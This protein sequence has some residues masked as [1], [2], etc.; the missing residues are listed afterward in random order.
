MI[1]H[2]TLLNMFP[3]E[4]FDPQQ[5]KPFTANDFIQRILIPE[6]AL[7]LIME[8]R[9]LKGFIGAETALQVLR[10]STAY[11]AA[12][13][14]EDDSEGTIVK[15]TNSNEDNDY[16]G[17]FDIG[18]GDKIVMERARK[19][20]KEIEEELE[21]QRELAMD[22]EEEQKRK[23]RGEVSIPIKTAS[24]VDERTLRTSPRPKV[25][26]RQ[27]KKNAVGTDS[28]VVS[29][30]EG[31]GS[32]LGIKTDGSQP[33]SRPKRNTRRVNYTDC[34]SDGDDD[35]SLEKRGR[36]KTAETRPILSAR[37]RSSFSR[38]VSAS[39]HSKKAAEAQVHFFSE[40]ASLPT[41]GLGSDEED[42]SDP[43]LKLQTSS[44]SSPKRK[45]GSKVN[46]GKHDKQGRTAYVD[47]DMDVDTP[48]PKRRVMKSIA[49]NEDIDLTPRRGMKPDQVSL[50]QKSGLRAHD[51]VLARA[52]A[53]T[54]GAR[55]VS[56]S[57]DLLLLCQ[58]RLM[59]VCPV[60]MVTRR[61]KTRLQPWKRKKVRRSL[62]GFLICVTILFRMIVAMEF[63]LCIPALLSPRATRCFE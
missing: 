15:K 35:E 56:S 38:Q 23:R 2:Q 32:D 51:S 1:I 60:S 55:C 24:D 45:P 54:R 11:G 20:R 34:S 22:T 44:A 9:G 48:M 14:P 3:L 33:R 36:A 43:K 12:M 25:S 41:I 19:R 8:D 28:D 18:I 58:S 29:I 57:Q 46:M 13:F 53:R 4:S 61:G 7:Q 27:R 42:W 26:S 47:V 16:N 49:E 59:C 40:D 52:R 21:D 39:R 37:S 17:G 62:N 6:V 10:D 30:T 50:S 5:I 63:C 31:E